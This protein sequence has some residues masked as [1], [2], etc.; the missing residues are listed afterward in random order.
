MRRHLKDNDPDNLD[1]T[2][3][4]WWTG[5]LSRENTPMMW[6]EGRS[7][8]VRRVLFERMRYELPFGFKL[9]RSCP[10]VTCV[11][12]WHTIEIGEGQPE[13]VAGIEIDPEVDELIEIILMRE[14]GRTLTP[15]QA[16]QRY[17]A[18]T[19]EQHTAAL[20]RIENERL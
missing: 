3:C 9:R 7:T 19:R 2:E 10:Y 1:E 6:H 13:P 11:N 15:E 5:S 4:W 17:P 12:P 18:Y 16:F 14:D 20:V 8:S